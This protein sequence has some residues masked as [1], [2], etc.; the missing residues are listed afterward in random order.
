MYDPS[1]ALRVSTAESVASPVP[2]QPV[3]PPPL[4]EKIGA[5]DHRQK[6]V[7]GMDNTANTPPMQP[8]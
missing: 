6:T 3:P 4:M 8:L 1:F 5:A 2:I 7:E